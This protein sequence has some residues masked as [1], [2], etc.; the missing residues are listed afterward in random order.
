M[1]FRVFAFTLAITSLGSA[2]ADTSSHAH[3]ALQSVPAGQVSLHAERDPLGGWNVQVRT[4]DFR[5]VPE[6]VNGAHVDGE[7]HAHIYI[8]GEKHR[9]IY[10]PWFHLD[11][12][13]PGSHEL[14][15][16]LN[17][18]SHSQLAVDGKALAAS[19]TLREE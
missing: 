8:N 11:P 2:L 18:H 5:F 16:T 19:T 9:R 1:R 12:L 15:V 7:G 10:G 13:G 17:G 6:K 3:H 14:K 4:Q